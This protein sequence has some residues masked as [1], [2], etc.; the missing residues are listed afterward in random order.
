[1]RSL[2]AGSP[3]RR[4]TEKEPLGAFVVALVLTTD[5][6]LR[7]IRTVQRTPLRFWSTSNSVSRR[8][9]SCFAFSLAEEPRCSG[10]WTRL[11][12]RLVARAAVV[13][14]GLDRGAVV[15][16][17]VERPVVGAVLGEAPQ[18]A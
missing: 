15:V 2:P 18:Q 6:P 16:S 7:W 12:V 17:G 10:P 13:V 8:P 1:M 3:M 14:A 4:S 11:T 5:L 9:P